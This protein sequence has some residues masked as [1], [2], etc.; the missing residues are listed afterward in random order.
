MRPVACTVVLCSMK[1]CLRSA[2]CPAGCLHS[3]HTALLRGHSLLRVY[4]RRRNVGRQSVWPGDQ[5]LADG[6]GRPRASGSA[7]GRTQRRLPE[8]LHGRPA[9][10]AGQRQ[11]GQLTRSVARHP[12]SNGPTH[13]GSDLSSI[14]KPPHQIINPFSSP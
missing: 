3:R 2:E 4:A 13:E 1:V 6:A 14:A 8:P 9:Q 10:P 5:R 7:A 11:T 12:L